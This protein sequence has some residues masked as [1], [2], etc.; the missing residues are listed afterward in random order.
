MHPTAYVHA[1]AHEDA[2]LDLYEGA[3]KD[4]IDLQQSEGALEKQIQSVDDRKEV[5]LNKKNFGVSS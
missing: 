4:H 2:K 5:L 3:P 1:P